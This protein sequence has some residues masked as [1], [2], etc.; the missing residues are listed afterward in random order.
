MMITN[1][2]K[3]DDNDRISH[4]EN[5]GQVRVEAAGWRVRGYG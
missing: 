4:N 3:D 2:D 5:D 1:D